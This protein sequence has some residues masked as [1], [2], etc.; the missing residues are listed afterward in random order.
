MKREGREVDQTTKFNH[1]LTPRVD[2][3][4]AAKAKHVSS[5][6]L[7]ITSALW[8]AEKAGEFA[9]NKQLDSTL[10]FFVKHDALLLART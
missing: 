2:R 9:V 5:L 1:T 7:D 8:P 6:T 4:P 3:T 10:L